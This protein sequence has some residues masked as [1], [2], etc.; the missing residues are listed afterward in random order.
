MVGVAG[1]EPAAPCSQSRCATGLR[2]TPIVERGPSRPSIS[3]GQQR[4]D[5]A[6]R[7]A[8]VI[9]PMLLGGRELAERAAERRIEEDGVVAESAS[10]A[11]RLADDAVDGALDDLLA[12]RQ[13]HQ[14][15]D[16]AEARGA[17]RGRH[18]A[19]ALEQQRVA[20]GVVETGSAEARRV[21]TRL[22][23]EGVDLEPG[24]VGERARAGR[25]G[26]RARLEERVLSIGRAGLF[27]K[28]GARDVG[29]QRDVP[30][31][32]AQQ[33]DE[34]APLG[35][36]ECRDD[37]TAGYRP[38]EKRH[39]FPGAL[40]AA[41]GVWGAISGPPIYCRRNTLSS[42]ASSAR[43]WSPTSWRM[44]RSARASRA[45]RRARSKGTCS[46]V[47]CTSTNSPPPV[48]T[49]FMSTSALESST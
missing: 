12:S 39:G 27:G 16:A 7:G 22:A 40:R 8:A 44:P 31:Q 33:L 29:Q 25:A 32:V 28:R 24:V 18:A 35:A 1:F 49:T 26:G 6:H 43:R 13:I 15:D 11:R 38:I 41:W 10:A 37:E 4:A 47:P 2:H 36:I 48:M 14:R 5:R 19:Q 45:S 23:P 17:P 21:E 9:H 34:L 3:N 42:R 20:A 46:A 30:R